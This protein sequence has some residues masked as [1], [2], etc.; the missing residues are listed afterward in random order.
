MA[1][2]FGCLLMQELSED[3]VLYLGEN[4]LIYRPHASSED[5]VNALTSRT[6]NPKS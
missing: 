2:R 4:E 1:T 5:L 3:Q 6:V